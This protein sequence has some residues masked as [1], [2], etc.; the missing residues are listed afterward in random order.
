MADARGAG[1]P[2]TSVHDDTRRAWEAASQKHVREYDELLAEARTARLLP[3]EEALLGDIVPGAEVVHP[4]SGHGL[5]DVALARLGARSVVGLD[6]S[7]TAVR[8]AARRAEEIGV[9]C[10]YVVA[11]LPES[12]LADGSADLV[13]T[14]KGALIWVEDLDVWLAEM[15]RVL[16]PGG[17][18]FAYEAHPLAPL[19]AWDADEVRV[20]ADRGYFATSH[21]NDS[22]PANGAVEHQRTLAAI[23]MAVTS[24]GFELLHLEEHPAPFWHPADVDAAAWH[25][26]VPNA[27]SLLARR[28]A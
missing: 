4:M 6:Y 18:L 3:V 20:R 17:H 28:S 7:P 25:G 26:Q 19:W 11:E 22:F 24:A 14:G 13:Y 1:G 15:C 23:V 10:R 5:D 16:R 12:G 27:F 8:A 9:P 21:V 2:A